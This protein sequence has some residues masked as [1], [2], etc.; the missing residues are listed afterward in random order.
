MITATPIDE[1]NNGVMHHDLSVP[2]DCFVM[3]KMP[4]MRDIQ[5][6]N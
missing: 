5:V 4:V 1:S 6:K 3:M 2:N